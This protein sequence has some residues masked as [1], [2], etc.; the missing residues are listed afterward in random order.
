MQPETPQGNQPAALPPVTPPV[1]PQAERHEGQEP[2]FYTPVN[3]SSYAGQT[4]ATPPTPAAASSIHWEASEY[5]HTD[6]GSLWLVVFGAVVVLLLGLAIWFAAWTFAILIVVMAVAMAIFAFRPPH[7]LHYV[8][9]DDGVQINNQTFAYN[10]FRA[11]GILQDGAF[12]TLTLIPIKRF[13][14]ALSVY[15]AEDHGEQI[16]DIVSAHLPMEHIE[17]DVIDTLMRRLR[18]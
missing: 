5:V 14:P 1:P 6:K 18:F 13:S 17:P 16:V 11:F 2:S 7:V 4:T 8:L 12:F 10:D 3:P 9:N 15:F